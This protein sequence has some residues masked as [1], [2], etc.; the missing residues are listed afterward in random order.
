M[1]I[2]YLHTSHRPLDT[3]DNSW[4]TTPLISGTEFKNRQAAGLVNDGVYQ[5]IKHLTHT[6]NLAPTEIFIDSKEANG[7][8]KTDHVNLNVV[9]NIQAAFDFIDDLD[10]IWVRGGFKPWI[11]LLTQLHK[12][13]T[14][15]IIFYRANSNYGGWPYWDIVL[16]DFVTMPQIIRNTLHYP[17]SKPVN[18]QL[19]YLQPMLKKY[20][21]MIGASHIHRHK[22]QAT[23]LK[24]IL[25]LQQATGKKYRVV[26]PGGMIRDTS[27]QFILDQHKKQETELYLPG[28]VSR[29]QLCTL[30]NQTKL[31]IHAGVSG[32]NDR[33]VLEAM[34]CGMPVIVVNPRRFSPFVAILAATPM[35]KSAT[36]P[37]LVADNLNEH[38]SI[39]YEANCALRQWYLSVNGLHQVCLPKMQRL[40]KFF[41]AY[42]LPDRRLA[43][44]QFMGEDADV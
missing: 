33:G 7:C 22:G 13:R 30:M 42:P 44:K 6:E 35:Y 2:V 38:W 36:L 29:H 43:I 16:N 14:N 8:H 24:A 41:K 37:D 11:P 26:L 23:I 12:R 34:A 20:D 31:F 15:W 27:N 40:T 17:Y 28:N 3:I 4:R 1:K 19:F 32:Q 9:S 5:L 21:I 10:I 25:D 18:E 39:N